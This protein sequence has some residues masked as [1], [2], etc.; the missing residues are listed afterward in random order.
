MPIFRIT[1][2][3][4]LLLAG[5]LT[6]AGWMGISAIARADRNATEGAIAVVLDDLAR[7]VE[8]G[9]R[10]GIAPA[11]LAATQAR[12][13]AAQAR[14]PV[15]RHV[16]VHDATGAQI[17]ATPPDPGPAAGQARIVRR[18]LDD[19]GAPT[20][21]IIATYDATAGQRRMQALAR[22]LIGGG[23]PVA[24]ILVLAGGFVVHRGLG[25]LQYLTQAPGAALA[26]SRALAGFDAVLDRI[27]AGADDRRC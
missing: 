11:A 27:A 14:L 15:L 17:F 24:A 6:L 18:V 21:T 7:T 2:V 20:A 23:L 19:L 8:S 3:M 4:S 1:L 16:A 25:R 13:A 5:G 9:A 22:A 12:I 10:L 26:R